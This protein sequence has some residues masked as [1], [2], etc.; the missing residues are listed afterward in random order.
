M[1]Y[2]VSDEY[3]YRAEPIEI[4]EIWLDDRKLTTSNKSLTLYGININGIVSEYT[5]I[6]VSWSE[7]PIPDISFIP[8]IGLISEIFFRL[9]NKDRQNI[10]ST[11]SMLI[12]TNVTANHSIQSNIIDTKKRSFN[13][14]ESKILFDGERLFHLTSFE[15]RTIETQTMSISQ[16]TSFDIDN[17]SRLY[18]VAVINSQVAFEI[19]VCFWG[20]PCSKCYPGETCEDNTYG[21]PELVCEK[22]DLRMVVVLSNVTDFHYSAIEE[23]SCSKK[24]TLF[25]YIFSEEDEKVVGYGLIFIGLLMM[26]AIYFKRE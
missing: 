5:T 12:N 23:L 19:L 10:V 25:G 1:R 21:L 2:I 18:S 3:S 7:T 8:K 20:S 6:N 11:S 9:D 22:M 4:K 24:S 14:Y 13:I 17:H 15:Y 16:Q 26:T